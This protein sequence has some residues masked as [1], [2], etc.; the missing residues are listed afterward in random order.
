VYAARL[1]FFKKAIAF[2]TIVYFVPAIIWIII[3]DKGDASSAQT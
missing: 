2:L 3:K 1:Q